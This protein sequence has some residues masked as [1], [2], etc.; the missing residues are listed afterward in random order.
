MQFESFYTEP[1]GPLKKKKN[2]VEVESSPMFLIYLLCF[3]KEKKK[4]QNLIINPKPIPLCKQKQEA[5]NL[6]S[7]ISNPGS[8]SLLRGISGNQDCILILPLQNG[9]NSTYLLHW[10]R[11]NWIFVEC[12]PVPET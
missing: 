4:S 12:G 3:G 6:G 2:E 8:V 7:Q 5:L 1:E 11:L 9:D 10:V